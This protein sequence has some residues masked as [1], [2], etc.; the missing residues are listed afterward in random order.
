MRMQGKRRKRRR[1]LVENGREQEKL[2][3]IQSM[4]G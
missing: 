4:R 1:V 2:Y 3:N